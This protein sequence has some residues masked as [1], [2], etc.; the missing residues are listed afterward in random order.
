MLNWKYLSFG[1]VSFK[2]F[3][4]IFIYISLIKFNKYIRE[5]EIS[6]H[7]LKSREF[8]PYTFRWR[9][10]SHYN[11]ITLLS[12]KILQKESLCILWSHWYP[13]YNLDL[14][15][16][17]MFYELVTGSFVSFS[18]FCSFILFYNVRFPRIPLYVD[19]PYTIRLILRTC[20]C[21][22]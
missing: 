4:K 5:E 21:F 10:I 19:L 14:T 7:V 17:Q 12:E 3:S 11:Y 15:P 9:E 8:A 18:S 2:V 22:L 20:L 16:Y 1:K 13:Y 6:P